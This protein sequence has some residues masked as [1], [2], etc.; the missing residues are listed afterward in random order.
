MLWHGDGIE[1]AE[2]SWRRLTHAVG[3]LRHQQRCNTKAS[4]HRCH[5]KA[6]MVVRTGHEITLSVLACMQH[7]QPVVNMRRAYRLDV[8]WAACIY[9]TELP[10]VHCN[11]AP[12][13]LQLEHFCSLVKVMRCYL[14]VARRC[15]VSRLSFQDRD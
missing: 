8:T 10:H 13:V 4:G 2:E 15:N 5:K 9:N 12:A 7:I 11:L 6:A 14:A 1:E 3:P